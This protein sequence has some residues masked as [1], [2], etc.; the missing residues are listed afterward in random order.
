MMITV[1]VLAMT[2]IGSGKM[3]KKKDMRKK[4]KKKDKKAKKVNRTRAVSMPNPATQLWGMQFLAS[5]SF[6]QQGL[7][8]GAS[9]L[10]VRQ[11]HRPHHWSSVLVL[12]L[13]SLFWAGTEEQPSLMSF[14]RGPI[15]ISGPVPNAPWVRP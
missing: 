12:V 14:K 4:D 15:I 1:K 8:P 11:S 2:K 6:L 7:A 9:R 3:I 13:R 5:G 10:H